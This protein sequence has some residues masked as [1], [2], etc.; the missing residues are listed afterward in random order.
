MYFARKIEVRADL[1]DQIIESGFLSVELLGEGGKLKAVA[2]RAELYDVL[3]NT[4]VDMAN[5][6]GLRCSVGYGDQEIDGPIVVE[7]RAEEGAEEGAVPSED[8]VTTTDHCRFYQHGK[9]VLHCEPDA[10]HVA[11]LL[12]WMDREQ[13]W[14]NCW[15]ISDHGNAHLMSLVP[16][17][18]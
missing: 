13:F 5:E 11:E 9:L 2:D 1:L 4:L 18:R 3:L 17:T 14:P 15:F 8:D 6:E 7:T 16:E 12:S 10:D